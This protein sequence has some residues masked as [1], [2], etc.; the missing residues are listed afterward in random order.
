MSDVQ[1]RDNPAENRYEAWLD[2]RLAG[3]AV[4]ET[5]G[6]SIVF[7]HT[8]VADEFEGRGV[9]SSLA[10]GALDDVR[11]RGGLDVVALCPFIKGWIEKH[12]D[13]EDLLH[14]R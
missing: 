3:F 4:Y 13:Y 2:G 1:V 5:R 11:A 14:R 8:E 6:S 10:R 9:G 7:T 12:P